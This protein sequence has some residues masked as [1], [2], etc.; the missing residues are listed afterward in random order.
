MLDEMLIRINKKHPVNRM[1]ATEIGLNHTRISTDVYE[2]VDRSLFL[3]S[4]IKHEIDF[5]PYESTKHIRIMEWNNYKGS[6]IEL[7]LQLESFPEHYYV[8]DEKR[9]LMA[10]LEHGIEFEEVEVEEVW[11]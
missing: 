7:G 10:T 11:K 8:S 9:F 2:V 5:N 6:A 3:V 4:V 1:K